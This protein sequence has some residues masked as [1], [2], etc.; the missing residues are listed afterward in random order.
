MSASLRSF[1]YTLQHNH[2]VGEGQLGHLLL[3]FAS[4]YVAYPQGEFHWDFASVGLLS[5]SLQEQLVDAWNLANIDQVKRSCRFFESDETT[6]EWLQFVA[7]N[8]AGERQDI[9]FSVAAKTGTEAY[10]NKVIADM[11]GVL[12]KA[13]ARSTGGG[14]F[15]F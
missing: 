7:T 12:G 14:R 9:A 13:G 10:K 11:E 2:I 8:D 5:L 4:S 6:A 3:N 15:G 1:K